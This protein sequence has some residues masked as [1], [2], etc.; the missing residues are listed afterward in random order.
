MSKKCK[1]R[2]SKS[3]PVWHRTS[4]QATLDAMPKF[5]GYACGTGA[6][7]DTRFNRAKSKRTWMRELAAD[8]ARMSGPYLLLTA[9]RV[10]C[11]TQTPPPFGSVQDRRV[12]AKRKEPHG[13]TP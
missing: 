12:R 1:K 2:V 3:G 4:E 13:A 11:V 9:G 8:K 10:A 7:G 5:N 6:H